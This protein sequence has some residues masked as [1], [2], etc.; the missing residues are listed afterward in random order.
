MPL[1]GLGAA[2][3][4]LTA[5]GLLW[6]RPH[7]LE[8]GTWARLYGWVGTALAAGLAYLA[9]CRL[10]LRTPGPA[11]GRA[12]WLPLALVLLAAAGMR[13][14]PLLHKPFLSSDVFRYV[15]DGRVQA[16]GVNPYRYL[17]SDPALEGL[18]DP[19]PW[20]NGIYSN[21]NRR[22]TARTIYPPAA[23]GLFLL[24]ALLWPGVLGWKVLLLA[25]EAVAVGVAAWLL[26][27]AGR[28]PAQVLLYAWAPLPA[29]E[30]A[31]N[32]HIDGAAIGFVA[33]ALGAAA[34]RRDLPAGLLLGAAALCKFLPTAL[35]PAMWR[36]FAS[37][38]GGAQGG[39][40][41][42]PLWG[43]LSASWR[44]PLAFAAAILAGYAFY[45]GAGWNVLGFLAGYG[46][47]EG[48]ASGTGIFWLRL[49]AVVTS[50]PPWIGKAY[51]LAGLAGLALLALHIAR[52]PL[53]DP[54]GPRGIE[55]ARGAL[56]L[57]GAAMAVITPHYA[58][59]LCW[60][61]WLACLYPAWSILA[62]TVLAPL[63][64]LDPDHDRIVPPALVFLPAALLVPLDLRKA[65][66]R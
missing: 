57:A 16:A 19:T 28:P 49:V 3:V 2:L 66:R 30:F 60:L 9:A 54:P 23:Q 27:R 42:G 24:S 65:A 38:R 58:W 48:L 61:T 22:D 50:L 33:L 46:D 20:P 10:V 1:G 45:L 56:L 37:P 29:W 44:L 8:I 40:Q 41:G 4:G 21:V 55:L 62:A 63:L 12:A 18:R 31:G 7:E 34:Y 52:T 64:Y 47:E 6:D 5:A 43:L 13:V 17:P 39:A 53:P 59:Y 25:L 51:L 15:W 26:N 32:G 14:P 35:L 36:P 11:S